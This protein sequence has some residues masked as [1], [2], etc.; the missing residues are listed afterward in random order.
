MAL[1]QFTRNYHDL[2]TDTGF[3]FEFFCDRCGNGFKSEFKA[4]TVGLAASALRTAGNLFGG[5]LGSASSNSYEIERC[6]IWLD[7]ERKIVR[8]AAIVAL[9]GSAARS[10]FGRAIT[11]IKMRGRTLQLPDGTPAFVTIHPSFL[12][13]IEDHTDKQREYRNFVADLALAAKILAQWAA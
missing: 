9:G 4:S 3:Q 2:S 6:R 8:P 5:I 7:L 1:I 13:R 11:I 12:L 10:L